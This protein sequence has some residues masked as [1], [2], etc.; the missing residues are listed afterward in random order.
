MGIPTATPES[1]AS[2]SGMVRPAEG[3]GEGE[4]ERQ[5]PRMDRVRHAE[6]PPQEEPTARRPRTVHP[7]ISALHSTDV[8]MERDRQEL[9]VTCQTR[10]LP[11]TEVCDQTNH[12]GWDR[13][14]FEICELFSRPR[15]CRSASKM[16]INSGYSLDIPTV[17]EITQRSYDFRQTA[18]Q[19]RLWS[20]LARRSPR[21]LIASPPCTTF[22]SL[23]HLRKTPMPTAE[24]EEGLLL[25][26][27]GIKACLTQLKNGRCFILEHPHAASS[28]ETPGLRRLRE[29]PE[30]IEIVLDQ[31]M[32]GLTSRDGNGQTPARKRTRILT[33]I[34]AAPMFLERQCDG[35][36]QHVHLLSGRAKAAQSYPEALCKAFIDAYVFERDHMKDMNSEHLLNSLEALH[37]SEIMTEP[38]EFDEHTGAPLDPQQVRAGRQ[39]E[40]NALKSRTVYTPVTRA[41]AMNSG[42][43]KFVKTRWVKSQKGAEV[44]CR[45]VAQ[46]FAN[47]DPREDLF[48]GTPPLFAA[49]LMVSLAA[50]HHSDGWSLMSLDISCAFLYAQAERELYIELP[51]EDPLYKTGNHVGR[52]DKALYGT[53]DAPQLWQKELNK[54]LQNM[55]FKCSKLHPGVYWNA[56]RCLTLVSHVDDLLV[57]GPDAEL[58]VM[59]AQ[60]AQAYEIKGQ[61]IKEGKGILKFLGRT[62]K[63]TYASYQWTGDDKHRTKL[64]DE[65]SM[66]QCSSIDTPTTGQ[67][68]PSVRETWEPMNGEEAGKFRRAVAMVN[69][70]AQDRPDLGVAANLL[71]RHMSTPRQGDERQLK[72]V[73]RYLRGRPT[74]SLEYEFS[75]APEYVLVLTDSDWAGCRVTRRST[76]GVIICVGTH[77][78]NFSCRMQKCVALSSGEAELNAQ[79]MGITEGV[80]IQNLLDEMG[81]SMG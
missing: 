75:S 19:T 42:T 37:E 13:C 54:T 16:G 12:R 24:R 51:E 36:H 52:L 74:C 46:E 43:G 73:L 67:E 65:W 11:K 15:V 39:R 69:Y 17:D 56:D 30:V 68:D 32:F 64:L 5:R 8:S 48:A 22:S 26:E 9:R 6:E 50:T 2:S 28:W 61:T 33:N 71:S 55:N 38:W 41:S 44:R 14:E 66:Q 79:V 80:G 1:M 70:M 77:V 18:D 62:I 49:R 45:F 35:S 76:S 20:L 81:I 58:H 53:R 10:V 27:V 34:R 63:E 25:L 72:R 23:Q 31:C 21:V 60:L 4:P 78:V 57:C 7:T 3:P 59:R 40:V 47:G 29:H